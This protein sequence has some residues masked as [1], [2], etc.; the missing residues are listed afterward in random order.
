MTNWIKQTIFYHIYPLGLCDAFYHNDYATPPIHRL[1]ALN[2]WLEHIAGMGFNGLYIGPLFES[3]WH[4]YDTTDYYHV[5][6]RLGDNEDLTR[7]TQKAHAL[8]IK[9]ILDCV[10]NHVGRDFWAFQDV[11]K[12]RENSQYKDWFAGL[13]F[14]KNN[15]HNDGL[16]YDCWEGHE[17]LVNLNLTNEGV[18]NH[19]FGAVSQWIRDYGID[20]L[21][22]DAA[23]VMDKTFLSKMAVHS[24][25]IDPNF[26]LMGEVIA[27]NYRDWANPDRLDSVTNY[28]CYK[29]LY[30]S[31]NDHN[32]FEIAWSLNRLFGSSGLYQDL[33][34][35][36]FADNHDVSRISSLLNNP[37]HLI[38][39]YTLMFTMP[40]VP[41]IYYGS[42]FGVQGRKE[43]GDSTL[44]P[45]LDLVKCLKENGNS[46]LFET[47]KRLIRVRKENYVFQVGSYRQLNL[48]NEQFAFTRESGGNFAITA[49][50]AADHFAAMEIQVPG[51]YS[52]SLM[53]LIQPGDLF[54][55]VNGTLHLDLA[56]NSVRLL[57]RQ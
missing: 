25:A 3:F 5:D 52:G 28:E 35:Y 30:S 9:V 8:G 4:G 48:T 46:N 29:G 18:Q 11:L 41:S 54:H 39:L 16:Q 15:K 42:E 51:G 50:N 56:P 55:P 34:L 36:S 12:N 32:F 10:F 13:T 38:P 2:P 23:N 26:W 37:A 31:F 24:H 7:L 14:T 22:L 1:E 49:L 20:G 17:N 19:L 6:R 21:R 33:Q 40:G 47:L 27:G 44:R 45:A 53:D 57:V 43:N